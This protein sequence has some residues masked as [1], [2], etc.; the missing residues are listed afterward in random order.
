[1]I[2]VWVT[3][4]HCDVSAAAVDD[5]WVSVDESLCEQLLVAGEEE[6]DGDE[7]S[8]TGSLASD[9]YGTYRGTSTSSTSGTYK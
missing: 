8:V 4:V 5:M 7:L 9:H 2:I 6:E 3:L 1:M